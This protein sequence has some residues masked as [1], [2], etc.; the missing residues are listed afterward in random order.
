M[1]NVIAKDTFLL[2]GMVPHSMMTGE[3]T[4]ISN[5][6]NFGWYEWVK[7]R[8][9][10]EPYPAPTEWLGRCLGPAANK[11]NE[12]SQYVLT[13]SGEVLPVQTLRKLTESDKSNPNEIKARKKMDEYIINRFVMLRV[14]LIIGSN[15][16][17]SRVIPSNS[18]MKMQYC[19]LK[20]M[21]HLHLNTIP[22]TMGRWNMS[23]LM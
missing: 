3:M 9:P 15:E 23:S 19:H 8:K 4:D 12:M 10:G 1:E 5:L 17:E 14:S 2:N 11:G 7:F 16:E 22:I 20:K 6:S 18:K 21:I 13:S